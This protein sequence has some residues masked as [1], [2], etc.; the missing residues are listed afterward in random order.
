MTTDA[1][2]PQ[3]NQP[4]PTSE[5][6]PPCCVCSSGRWWWLAVPVLAL[7]LILL[8]RGSGKTENP[9][10]GLAEGINWNSNYQSAMELAQKEKKPVLLVFS[11]TWCPPC[12]N[13][14]KTT[15]HDPA[16]VKVAQGFIPIMV[17]TDENVDLAQQYGVS[18][19]PCYFLLRPDGT[20][21]DSFV[22]YHKA[23]DFAA[24]LKIALEKSA[25]SG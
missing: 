22:G 18:G 1:N 16:V 12:Q 20:Q 21:I 17:D 15:Y 7:I 23:S 25:A 6:P 13:M 14:K 10:S 9:V 19:I 24:K 4:G 11:A 2:F 3:Q 5:S 8:F